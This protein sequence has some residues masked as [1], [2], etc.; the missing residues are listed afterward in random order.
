M[1]RPSINCDFTMAWQTLG[2][3]QESCLM[4]KMNKSAPEGKKSPRVK[5]KLTIAALLSREETPNFAYR[6]SPLVSITSLYQ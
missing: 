2:I 1:T 3:L 6:F 5:S 4:G